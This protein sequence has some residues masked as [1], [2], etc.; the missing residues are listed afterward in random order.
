MCLIKSLKRHLHLIVVLSWTCWYVLIDLYTIQIFRCWYFN[1][2]GILG[3]KIYPLLRCAHIHTKFDMYITTA[4]KTVL[5]ILS[6]KYALVMCTSLVVFCFAS[7][8]SLSLAPPRR[9]QCTPS[10]FDNVAEI[11]HMYTC[12]YVRTRIA[13]VVGQIGASQTPSALNIQV[14]GRPLIVS[15]CFL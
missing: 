1:L 4:C 8:T 14:Y 6:D 12:S 10:P 7:L 5:A 9:N 3:S 11:C 2:R 15:M 13:L